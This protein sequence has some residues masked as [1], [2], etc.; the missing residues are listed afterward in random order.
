MNCDELF[1]RC[2]KET[3]RWLR[4]QQE[5]N[6]I[7][8]ALVEMCQRRQRIKR[9]WCTNIAGTGQDDFFQSSVTNLL[10][11]RNHGGIPGVRRHRMM[12]GDIVLGWGWSTG[13]WR[14]RA[15]PRL[16]IIHAAQVSNSQPL[17]IAAPGQHE[18]WQDKQSR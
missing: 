5:A 12:N 7:R 4:L 13:L 6:R 15:V 14:K 18:P 2:A 1:G 9:S 11:C 16:A 17:L 8:I 3:V 10:N